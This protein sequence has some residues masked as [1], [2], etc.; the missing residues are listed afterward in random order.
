MDIDRIKGTKD[1]LLGSAKQ[2]AGELV[3]DAGLQVEGMVQQ[4]KGNLE[5]AWG[6][7]KDVVREANEEAAVRHETR[8]KVELD[9]AA[10]EAG[11]N[12][13]R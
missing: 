6:K 2:K 11:R 12:E 4:V 1:V 8:L 5:N 9:L 7:A 13:S 3:G 10:E